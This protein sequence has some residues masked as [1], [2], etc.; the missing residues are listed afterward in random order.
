MQPKD[1]DSYVLNI[2]CKI[3]KN[4][5]ERKDGSPL[6]TFAL[7]IDQQARKQTVNNWTLYRHPTQG[8]KYTILNKHHHRGLI[9][10][11]SGKKLASRTV[12]IY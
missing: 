11:I 8:D 10:N 9:K 4:F 12:T 3:G 1:I 5:T 6:A 2:I 7:L